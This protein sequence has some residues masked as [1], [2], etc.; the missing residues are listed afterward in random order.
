MHW[1]NYPSSIQIDLIVTGET[2]HIIKTYAMH[3]HHMASSHIKTEKCVHI[4]LEYPQSSPLQSKKKIKNSI[5]PENK[6]IYW[7][8]HE[9][10][11]IHPLILILQGYIYIENFINISRSL[12]ILRVKPEKSRVKLWLNYH[13]HRIFP[14]IHI[15]N[16]GTRAA[17]TNI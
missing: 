5:R 4:Y 16:T 8:F 3:I 10:R 7:M 1:P 11:K 14:N 6:W 13:Q 17:T 15:I 9:P 12:A 2:W